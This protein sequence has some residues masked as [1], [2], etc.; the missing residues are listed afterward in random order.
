MLPALLRKFSSNLIAAS[1]LKRQSFILFADLD[2]ANHRNASAST[3]AED[4]NPNV[5]VGRLFS[6]VATLSSCSG[7]CSAAL[8]RFGEDCLSNSFVSSFVAPL[9]RTMRISKT[10]VHMAVVASFL[11]CDNLGSRANGKFFRSSLGSLFVCKV[12]DSSRWRF[13]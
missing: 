7:V 10:T 1:H 9:P 5:F 12:N 8:V 6:F 4:I 3:F 11:F 13:L 2:S